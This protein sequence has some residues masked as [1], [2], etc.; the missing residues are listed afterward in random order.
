MSHVTY[1]TSAYMELHGKKK[2]ELS[3]F[4]LLKQNHLTNL[5]IVVPRNLGFWW[6]D[7]GDVQQWCGFGNDG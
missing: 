1:M 6:C 2:K 3:L 4:N 5:T 7:G